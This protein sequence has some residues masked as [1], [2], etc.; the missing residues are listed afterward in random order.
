MDEGGGV[1]IL[2]FLAWGCTCAAV[3]A[4]R[5]RN[6][7]G[8]FLIGALISPLGLIVLLSM[9]N[10]NLVAQ[11]ALAV[12]SFT[13][14]REDVERR[15]ESKPRDTMLCPW[16]AET[17]KAAAKICRFCNREVAAQ[18]AATTVEPAPPRLQKP[19]R[20]VCSS[21]GANR[22]FGLDGALVLKCWH[23]GGE[24]A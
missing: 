8:W 20:P 3:A 21:C 24:C 16:C 5:G 13:E 1:L 7:I 14:Q 2:W 22:M 18:E 12:R 4:V 17:I 15:Y 23:C 19:P 10:L 9:P 6:A 11:T